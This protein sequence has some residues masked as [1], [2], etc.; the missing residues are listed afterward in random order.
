MPAIDMNNADALFHG[1]SEGTKLYVGPTLVWMKPAGGGT[2]TAYT[3]HA[4]QNSGTPQPNWTFPSVNLGTPE[5]NR[6][7][8]IWATTAAGGTGALP[9]TCTVAGIT[10]NVTALSSNSGNLGASIFDVDVPS[11]STGDIFIGLPASTAARALSVSVYAAYGKS[12]VNPIL[13][14]GTVTSADVSQNVL[15]GDDVLAFYAVGDGF[16]ATFTGVTEDVM[17][18]IR[19]GEWVGTGHAYNVAAETPRTITFAWGGSSEPVSQ[20]SLILR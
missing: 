6:K 16:Q 1:A 18:D 7:L 10:A 5:A 17:V 20:G 9:A 19:S 12:I 11:G 14:G 13:S 2:S 15:A 8:I 3:A 4:S